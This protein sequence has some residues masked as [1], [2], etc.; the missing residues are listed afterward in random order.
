V[1]DAVAVQYNWNQVAPGPWTGAMVADAKAPAGYDGLLVPASSPRVVISPTL[2][3]LAGV[4][5]TVELQ[6]WVKHVERM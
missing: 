5:D 6:I 2:A 3:A 4:G 1:L